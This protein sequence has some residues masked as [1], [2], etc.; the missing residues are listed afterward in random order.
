MP[1]VI[2]KSE[3]RYKKLLENYEKALSYFFKKDYKKAEEILKNIIKSEKDEKEL[4]KKA[5]VYLRLCEHRINQPKHDLKS[6]DDFINFAVY[7]MNR[8]ELDEAEE[9]LKKAEK[10][11]KKNPRIYYLLANLYA[12]KEK[13][14]KAISYLKKAIKKDEIY[15]VYASVNPDFSVFSENEELTELLKDEDEEKEKND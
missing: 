4:I 12:L 6:I 3:E 2:L 9:V 1:D 15:K 8:K 10:K 11:D 7:Q 13:E 5:K 14:E